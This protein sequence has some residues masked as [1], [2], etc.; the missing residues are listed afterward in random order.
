[1]LKVFVVVFVLI[2]LLLA[3][4]ATR[5]DG[6]RL[7][8]TIIIKASPEKVFALIN[9]FHKWGAWSPWD[10]IDADLKRTY[11]GPLSGVGATYSWEGK[12]TGIGRMVVMEC[13][14]TSLVKIK[15]DFFKPFEA[16]NVAEFSLHEQDDSTVVTWAMSG[17]TP[18]LSKLIGIFFSMDKLVGKQFE[19]GLEKMKSAAETVGS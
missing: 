19:S 1:M 14:P 8:R 2:A 10:K 3:Y 17:P 16:H 7:E 12:K 6:F 11:S 15:L 18:Y 5:P 13:L 9:D 4:A